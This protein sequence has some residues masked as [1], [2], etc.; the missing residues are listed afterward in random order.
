MAVDPRPRGGVDVTIQPRNLRR[1]PLV[2]VHASAVIGCTGAEVRLATA[3]DPL[4]TGLF[5]QGAARP[6]PLGLGLDTDNTGRLIDAEGRPSPALW[7][8]GPL[9][10]GQ[11]LETTAIPEIRGQAAALAR[12]L[13][14][15]LPIRAASAVPAARA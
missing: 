8:L 4:F 14:A 10:R 2:R 11:L 9:R 12:A 3:R 15:E 1:D 6:G 5:Q 13:T 7:T